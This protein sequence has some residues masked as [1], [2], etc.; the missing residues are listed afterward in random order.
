MLE[1]TFLECCRCYIVLHFIFWN[2]RSSHWIASLPFCRLSRASCEWLILDFIC[3]CWSLL[4][5]SAARDCWFLC[6]SAAR[7]CWS[8]FFHS[9]ARDCWFLS[10]IAARD[11][12]SS[13]ANFPRRYKAAPT[14]RVFSRRH[15]AAVTLQCKTELDVYSALLV[16]HFSHLLFEISLVNQNSHVIH[17]P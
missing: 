6:H 16:M 8:F 13:P 4:Y 2:G 12:W 7:D 9:A 11:R 3:V 15:A 14:S 1:G 10:L 17:V 5:C